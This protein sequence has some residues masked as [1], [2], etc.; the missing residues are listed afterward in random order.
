MN[1][2]RSKVKPSTWLMLL[3]WLVYA[4]SYMGKVNY[5]ANVNQVMSFYQV[6]H[7]SAGLV[8][9][10]FFFAYGIGQVI[11]GLFCK[12]Y[13]LRWMIFSS[14]ILSGC[15]N[16]IV[17]LTNNFAIIKYLWLFNG[18]AMSVLWPSLIRC[19]SEN[20]NKSTMPK[21]S[22]TMGTTVA[23]GT[24]LIYLL[25]A[26]FVKIE[27]KL[28][29]YLPAGIFFVVAFIWLFSYTKLISKV[30]T[31][32]EEKTEVVKQEVGKG[33]GYNKNLILL[34]ICT[35]ALYGV[36]TNL[37]KDGLVTWVPSILKEQYNL[38]NSISIVLT[39][40]L[41]I[42]SMFA[43]AFAIKVHSKISDFVLQCA[44]TFF[45]AGLI[46]G[47]VI[48]GISLNQFILTLLGFTV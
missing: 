45:C 18:L 3:C 13:N 48:V 41:P 28:S 32:T 14:L 34:S 36:A 39:L 1:T 24:F 2:K 20:L 8:S 33:D 31:E 21:A 47:G 25:S 37:I 23:T 30:K 26:L 6:D 7:S 12:K 10:F 38:D 9:T 15:V 22:M 43:N 5:S 17:G 11:N 46:I 16:L 35:L 4:C 29:F 44:T 19:L 42:V 27:F 40:A